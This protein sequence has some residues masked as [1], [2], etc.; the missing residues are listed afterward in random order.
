MQTVG[1]ALKTKQDKVRV[2]FFP[3]MQNTNYKNTENDAQ[4]IKK[5]IKKMTIKHATT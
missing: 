5:T 3:K 4:T 1:Q 2:V